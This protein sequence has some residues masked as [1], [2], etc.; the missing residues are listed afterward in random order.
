MATTDWEAQLAAEGA[1]GSADARLP[2]E[3]LFA[4]ADDAAAKRELVHGQFVP[5][6][7]DFWFYDGMCTLLEV[8][9]LADADDPEKAAAAW[10]ALQ[11]NKAQLETL[12]QRLASS[13]CWRRVQ[14]IR[15]RRL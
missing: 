10:R 4:L 8:Q 11:E 7:P 13:G 14:R 12:E 2:F 15:R 3:E 5:G 9:A 1:V 6:S